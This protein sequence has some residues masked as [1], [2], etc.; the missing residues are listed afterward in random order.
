VYDKLFTLRRAGPQSQIHLRSAVA[1]LYGAGATF[2][3]QKKQAIA[4]FFMLY[5]VCAHKRDACASG[6]ISYNKN[7]NLIPVSNPVLGFFL[8]LFSLHHH[9]II[10]SLNKQFSQNSCT[11]NHKIH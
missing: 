6:S 9:I 4:C 8:S 1:K 2:L 11:K 7:K 10:I 3:K 5:F